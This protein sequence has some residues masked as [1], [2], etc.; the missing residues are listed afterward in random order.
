MWPLE[1]AI[2]P[3]QEDWRTESSTSREGG[4]CMV[5]GVCVHGGGGVCMVVGV[6]VC[7]DARAGC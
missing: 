1:G 6:G 3:A 4:V 2:G 5:V 7:M